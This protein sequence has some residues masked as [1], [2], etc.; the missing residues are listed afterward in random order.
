M[1][2][3]KTHV[4]TTILHQPPWL[5]VEQREIE[6]PDGHRVGAW[7]FVITP[8]YV[9][10]MAQTTEGVFVCFRQVKYAYDGL[11][12]AVVGGYV[13]P[14]EDPLAAA[15]RELFEETGYAADEW[16]SFGS[17]VPDANRGCG[18][19]HLFLARGARLVG[20]PTEIDREQPEMILLTRDE[21]E[22]ALFQNQFK[23]LAWTAAVAL[24]LAY[25]NSE[26]AG[27]TARKSA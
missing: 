2:A 1:Q 11:S 26:H 9:N 27:T 3:F 8:H 5:T 16:V 21:V 12:L 15:K 10:L 22:Q 14:G 18:L 7:P 4:R 20:A 25:L 17:H 19:A 24:T 6:F 13:E 23:V